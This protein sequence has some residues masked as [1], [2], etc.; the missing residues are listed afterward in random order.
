MSQQSRKEFEVWQ[1]CNA[2]QAEGQKITYRALGDKLVVLGYK[3]GSNSE[4]F[5]YLSTW[6]DKNGLEQSDDTP[7]SSNR[8]DFGV[9]VKNSLETIQNEFLQYTQKTLS[10][11]QTEQSKL[12]SST[13]LTPSPLLST[14]PVVKVQHAEPLVV[15]ALEK[16]L[17]R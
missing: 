16:V 12:P 4:I 14:E 15:D 11:L 3:R 10:L 5:R 8:G 6:R 1:A 7:S 2:L 17:T 9:V 13:T